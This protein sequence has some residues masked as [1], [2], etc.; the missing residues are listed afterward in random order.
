[1]LIYF[2][3]W[4]FV[5]KG[6]GSTSMSEWPEPPLPW[7]VCL[8]IVHSTSTGTC[9][10]M[11]TIQQAT[12][13]DPRFILSRQHLGVSILWGSLSIYQWNMTMY[14]AELR[15]ILSH[16]PLLSA[17]NRAAPQ[18]WNGRC[19]I[20]LRESLP[21]CTTLRSA[22]SEVVCNTMEQ[23]ITQT[24]TRRNGVYAPEASIQFRIQGRWSRISS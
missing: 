18:A 24:R 11:K 10:A 1:M 7:F 19:F 20:R 21:D 14:I 12:L 2:R 6:F 15:Y 4:S 9:K 5:T 3:A 23:W 22:P 8:L 17:D 16:V 13:S